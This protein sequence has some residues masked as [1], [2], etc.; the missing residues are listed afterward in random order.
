MTEATGPEHPDCESAQTTPPAPATAEPR[1]LF[2]L[3]WW[4]P[5][6]V[7]LPSFV[8]RLF[9][10]WV[11]RPLIDD[12]SLNVPTAY[13][14]TLHGFIGPDNWWTQPLKHLLLYPFLVVFGN[15]PAGWRIRGVIFGALMVWL[16]FL[17]ARRAFN[18]PFVAWATA[19]LVALDPILLVMSRTPTEEIL[20][21][22]ALLGAT[23]LAQRFV[24]SQH[25]RDLVW[26]GIVLGAGIA[27]RIYMV[28]P[29]AFVVACVAWTMRRDLPRAGLWIL[30]YL[31]AIPLAFFVA[32]YL[33][34]ATRGYA[35]PE[36]VGLQIDVIRVQGRSFGFPQ[37]A[38]VAGAHRWVLKGIRVGYRIGADGTRSAYNLLMTNAALMPLAGL[39]TLYVTGR[40][41]IRRQTSELVAVGVLLTLYGFYLLSPR[42][43]YVYSSVPIIP[44]LLMCLASAIGDL[45]R[46]PRILAISLALAWSVYLY[47]L[48]SAVV[49]PNWAYDWFIGKQRL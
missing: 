7:L 24:E 12:S 40:A 1:A 26:L 17:V 34:W 25:E 16:V 5:F 18:S 45:P 15:D 13:Y 20:A 42:P 31:C 3:E 4:A 47:P 49:I 19:C 23:L 6:A 33:P 9:R 43:V 28:I 10:Y 22:C 46:R 38:D 27:L 36:W 30:G 21:A 37:L 32:A 39:A 48:T 44:L 14:Y 2:P 29:W 11:A 8:L 35:L 41:T